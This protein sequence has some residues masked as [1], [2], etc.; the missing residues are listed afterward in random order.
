MSTF[1]AQEDSNK[2][3]LPE[4]GLMNFLVQRPDEYCAEGCLFTDLANMSCDK[5][6][7]NDACDY[8]AGDC[9][10]ELDQFMVAT[11][12]NFIESS[13]GAQWWWKP[14]PAA[15]DSSE[16]DKEEGDVNDD[17]DAK[18]DDDGVLESQDVNEAEVQGSGD[19]EESASSSEKSIWNAI[20]S[21][22]SAF[23]ADDLLV[24]GLCL[25]DKEKCGKIGSA[26]TMAKQYF[27]SL[28]YHNDNAKD[29]HR[30]RARQGEYR[31]SVEDYCN[32]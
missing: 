3:I 32:Y 8:D 11:Q 12:T 21:V 23:G 24:Q 25:L 29:H 20:N 18:D 15:P 17:L 5:L 4:S 22:L 27:Q 26:V 19:K 31:Q 28:E 10:S 2:V 6:C 16:D 30:R 13:L 14:K 1:F 7:F 9:D